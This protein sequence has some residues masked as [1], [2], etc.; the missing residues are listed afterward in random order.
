MSE[1]VPAG[2]DVPKAVVRYFESVNTEDYDT[3]REQL[4]PDAEFVAVGARPRRGR[5]EV[6]TY[7][8]A[9]FQQLP[10]HN[11]EPTRYLIAGDAVTVEIHFVGKT[12]AG[13]HVEFD[14]IDVMDLQDGLI[15]RVTSWYDSARVQATIVGAVLT[16]DRAVPRI[17]RDVED[18]SHG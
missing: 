17:G 9:A 8:P 7:F 10:E 6:M 1:V 11:D 15:R 2:A 4:H 12:R 3:L 14:A 13:G 16:G 18:A 5:E